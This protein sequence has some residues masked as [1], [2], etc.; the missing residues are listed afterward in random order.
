[1]RLV[2]SRIY[3][4]DDC[5]IDLSYSGKCVDLTLQLVFGGVWKSEFVFTLIPVA[6]EKVDLLEARL[7]D[8]Y[9]EIEAL[10]AGNTACYLSLSTKSVCWYDQ[11]VC[12]DGD[13]LV[14]STSH[15][16]LSPDMKRVTI[17]KPGVYHI[18]VRLAGTNDGDGNSTGLQLNGTDIAICFQCD[19]SG[20]SS[21]SQL[22]EVVK[23]LVNDVLQV[24]N[25][26]NGNT[27]ETQTGNRF[28]MHFLG[29]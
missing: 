23:L 17:L 5:K 4:E 16:K 11:I 21:T 26:F 29:N 1:M 27:L 18:N 10:R 22:H 13:R 7:R 14:V 3:S 20:F 28:T 8:A 19:E 2:E 15:F 9:D 25:G 12:W 24:R 6:L